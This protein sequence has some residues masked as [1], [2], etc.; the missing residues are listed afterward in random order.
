[1]QAN[2]GRLVSPTLGHSKYVTKWVTCREKPE[3][4]QN[5]KQFDISGRPLACSLKIQQAISDE[6]FL[7]K[8]VKGMVENRV[9]E[10]AVINSPCE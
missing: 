4:K 8:R 7:P 3:K 5:A 9:L 6:R 1:M 2:F 10:A